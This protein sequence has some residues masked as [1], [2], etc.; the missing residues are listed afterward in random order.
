LAY[1][2][3]CCHEAHTLLYA[4]FAPFS[5]FDPNKLLTRIWLGC[6]ASV[7]CRSF[8]ILQI[9]YAYFN[10]LLF[11]ILCVYHYTPHI[12]AL[13]SRSGAGYAEEKGLLPRLLPGKI[14]CCIGKHSAYNFCF[15]NF[16]PAMKSHSVCDSKC[17]AFFSIL[18]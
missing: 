7:L 17:N 6:N 5:T 12:F 1:P 11:S 8:L 15:S 18:L 14:F 9:T 16:L 2:P 10:A 3:N 13:L 4:L